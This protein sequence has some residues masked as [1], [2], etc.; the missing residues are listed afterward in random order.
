MAIAR[1]VRPL[2]SSPS[3]TPEAASTLIIGAA[4]PTNTT[5][6]LRKAS[7]AFLGADHASRPG[8]RTARHQPGQLADLIKFWHPGGDQ[9][10]QTLVS[11]TAP[12]WLDYGGLAPD[13]M[14][15][16]HAPTLISVGELDEI[17]PL[18]LLVGR[19]RTPSS[20][21]A[22]MP[23]TSRRSRQTRPADSPPRS[24]SSPS[25]SAAAPGGRGAGGGQ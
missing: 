25:D 11:Q 1:A 2:S 20:P 23:T 18:D 10:W 22:R 5:T 8:S 15:R 6:G 9:Q 16:V 24:V 7:R 19:L 17:H 13:D 4:Y 3:A 14:P 12:R 21:S